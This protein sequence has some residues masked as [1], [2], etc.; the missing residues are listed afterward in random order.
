MGGWSGAA[1]GLRTAIDALCAGLLLLAIVGA[2]GVLLLVAQI[3]STAGELHE[4]D[5]SVQAV[6]RARF[7][8]LLA[9]RAYVLDALSP[10]KGYDEQQR[11]YEAELARW[12]EEAGAHVQGEEE[13]RLFAQVLAQTDELTETLKQPAESP[14]DALERITLLQDVAM[15]AS[16]ELLQLNRD[17]AAAA[18]ERAN[19]ARRIAT[20]V[21][22]ASGIGLLIVAF[23]L[24][25]ASR[26][27]LYR[28]IVQ[29]EHAIA[30]YGSGDHDARMPRAGPAELRVISDAFA[31][32]AEALEAQRQRQLTFLAA[33]AHDLRNP[34]STLKTAGK[35]IERDLRG[36]PER[37]VQRFELI[38]RQIDRLGR[39]VDDLLDV[40]RAEAGG[41]VI[42][43]RRG[44]LCAAVREAALLF[45]HASAKHVIETRLPD[46]PVEA[47]F[48]PLRF[49]QVM[50]NL[51][52]NAIKYSPAGGTIR[53][54]VDRADGVACVTVRDPG[55][56][57]AHEDLERIFEPFHRGAAAAGE[58]PGA[59]LGL[60][61]V[62]R[63]VHAHGGTI[64]VE[65]VPG[66]G[67]IFRVRLPLVEAG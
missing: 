22:S 6:Q 38:G 26:R 42:E 65:S 67:S 14:L 36:A 4:Y 19:R 40:S 17:Q 54:E 7:T 57:I 2:G 3:N 27:V 48:D 62:R 58:I 45:E 28:P 37:A 41:L 18:I 35:L 59:G 56:G 53:V 10:G 8:S 25:F 9:G 50:V 46:E 60:S 51:L 5:Q 21:A 32:M 55:R 20:V 66:G 47:D 23:A 29:L 61:A 44:D 64:E 12:L 39:M 63:L 16:A 1:I 15:A 11:L 31:R 52:S 13:A 34:L 24:A 43:K 30:S 49:D 33:I